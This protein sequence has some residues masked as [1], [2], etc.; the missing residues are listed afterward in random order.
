MYRSGIYRS[1]T[2]LT[3][4][5]VVHVPKWSKFRI[6]RKTC[7]EV[8]CTEMVMYRT[9]PN[10]TRPASQATPV[11]VVTATMRG[12]NCEWP[13]TSQKSQLIDEQLINRGQSSTVIL[14]LHQSVVRDALRQRTMM[15]NPESRQ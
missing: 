12:A 14:Y 15:R 4:T 13:L 7:T 8:V 5:E 11:L 3:C 2:P 9:G 1:G 10:P 6:W